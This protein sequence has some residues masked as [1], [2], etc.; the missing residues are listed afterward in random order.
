MS[1]SLFYFIVLQVVFCFNNN[2]VFFIMALW[3]NSTLTI[4]KNPITHL[5][6]TN[7]SLTNSMQPTEDGIL[8]LE[9]KIG[10]LY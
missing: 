9:D 2:V 5:E 1:G 7:E 10:G 3:Y 8:R 4:V 6:N